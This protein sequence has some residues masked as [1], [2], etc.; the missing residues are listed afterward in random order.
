MLIKKQF[1]QS[2]EIVVNKKEVGLFLYTER[3][4]AREPQLDRLR[5][6]NC[7]F[8]VFSCATAGRHSSHALSAVAPQFS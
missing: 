4:T 3:A 7:G 2:E 8:P 6:V 5:C 1:N